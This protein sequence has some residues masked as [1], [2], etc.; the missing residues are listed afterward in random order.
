MIKLGIFEIN[1][2]GIVTVVTSVL[3]L[4]FAFLSWRNQVKAK[5]DVFV[6]PYFLTN[7]PMLQFKSVSQGT[8]IISNVGY[9][10]I[11]VIDILLCVGKEKIPVKYVFEDEKIN[12]S[13]SPGEVKYYNY[14]KNELIEYISRKNFHENKRI[15][16]EIC[17]NT[18]QTFRYKTKIKISE[19]IDM[20]KED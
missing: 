8:V 9:K 5:L 3:A 16:W 18:R 15:E 6:E 11:T 2:E 19:V 14:D 20:N 10:T 13:I 7:N 4:V 1:I 12:I 17:T